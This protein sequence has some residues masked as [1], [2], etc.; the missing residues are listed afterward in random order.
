MKNVL[1]SEVK[2]ATEVLDVIENPVAVVNGDTATVQ[3]DGDQSDVEYATSDLEG[4]FDD[5]PEHAR[6]GDEKAH[7]IMRGK[8]RL[9]VEGNTLIIEDNKR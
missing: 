4:L 7:D 1:A 5:A 6:Y 9:R 3:G 8:R 2:A